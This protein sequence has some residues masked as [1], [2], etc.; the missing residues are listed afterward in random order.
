MDQLSVKR[1]FM[2]NCSFPHC[3]PARV[4][5]SLISHIEDLYLSGLTQGW[6]GDYQLLYL[7]P[8]CQ[9]LIMGAEIQICVVINSIKTLHI[10]LTIVHV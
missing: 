3:S 2:H 6:M 1:L 4:D 8:T 5:P 7:G 10:I 9:Q